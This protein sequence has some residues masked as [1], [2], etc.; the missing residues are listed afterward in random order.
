MLNI[1]SLVSVGRL[2]RKRIWLGGALSTPWLDSAAEGAGT[3]APGWKIIRINKNMHLINQMSTSKKCH[4]ARGKLGFYFARLRDI[5]ENYTKKSNHHYFSIDQTN[6]LS[7]Y[8]AQIKGSNLI[9]LLLTFPFLP[10]FLSASAFLGRSVKVPFILA[11]M[12][13]SA[14]E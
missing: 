11:I 14:R 6:P 1:I 12:S 8:L 10:F 5:N 2:V 13:E 9:K 3:G 4:W 7:P